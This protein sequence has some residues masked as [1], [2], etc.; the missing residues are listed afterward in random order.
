MRLQPVSTS[1]L[2]LL[3]A[4]LACNE[5]P[6]ELPKWTAPVLDEAEVISAADEELMNNFVRVLEKRTGAQIAVF[7]VS[8][9]AGQEPSMLATK[10]AERWGVG[11]KE[12]DNGVLVL[13][14]PG[15]RKDFTATGRGVEGVLP[16]SLVGSLRREILVP[17]FKANDYGGGLRQYLYELGVRIAAE[18]ETKPGELTNDF[19]QLLGVNGAVPLVD[20]GAQRKP[21]KKRQ[22]WAN[23]LVL[24]FILLTMVGGGMR[25]R[26]RYGFWGAMMMTGMGGRSSGRSSGGFGGGFGGGGGSFGGGGAGGSW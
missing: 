14:A 24:A 6:R 25:G 4:V 16:D 26:R 21:G 1:W 20:N 5:K 11:N 18:A 22:S 10:T 17:A 15:D 8:T 2:L 12:K 19:A 3:V 7:T 23:W 13:V 9:L